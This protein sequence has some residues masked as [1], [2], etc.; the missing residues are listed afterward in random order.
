VTAFVDRADS[1][2]ELPDWKEFTSNAV[3][4]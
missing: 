3:T 2:L 1:R 4:E